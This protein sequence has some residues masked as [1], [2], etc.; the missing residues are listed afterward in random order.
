MSLPSPGAAFK[1]V[2]LRKLSPLPLRLR[3][4]RDRDR[5]RDKD[6][7]PC[8][9]T[10]TG[11]GG[12]EVTSFNE[13]R[14]ELASEADADADG[15]FNFDSPAHAV[16]NTS[17]TPWPADAK[18][19]RRSASATSW[20]ASCASSRSSNQRS[21]YSDDEG[22]TIKSDINTYMANRMLEYARE[23]GIVDFHALVLDSAEMRTTRA[24]RASA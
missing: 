10:C 15:L 6:E 2:V 5:E 16:G 22:I 13:V 4:E 14:D 23:W 24:S 1:Y 20:K 7:A 12:T 9:R 18:G 21:V 17:C 11:R 8:C 19:T 3:G